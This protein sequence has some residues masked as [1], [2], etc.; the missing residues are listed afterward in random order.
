MKNPLGFAAFSRLDVEDSFL[1]D[2][3]LFLALNVML[4]LPGRRLGSVSRRQLF[5]FVFLAGSCLGS[6]S[7]RQLLLQ[8]VKVWRLHGPNP[9]KFH[10]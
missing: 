9:P 4:F 2:V 3:M 1:A 5:R 7:C 10:L 8:A 6:V